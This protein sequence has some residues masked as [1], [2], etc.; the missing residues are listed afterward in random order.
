MVKT[1]LLVMS[2]ET[3]MENAVDYRVNMSTLHMT[4][5]FLVFFILLSFRTKLLLSN[6]PSVM[7]TRIALGFKR[8]QVSLVVVVVVVVRVP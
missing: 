8:D 6:N 2:Q 4:G 5:P 7:V 3:L 1:S